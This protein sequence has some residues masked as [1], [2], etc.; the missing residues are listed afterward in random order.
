M[1]TE[2]NLIKLLREK[3]FV[4]NFEIKFI[5]KDKTIKTGLASARII[6][7]DGEEHILSVT[8]DITDWKKAEEKR[9]YLERQVR[10]NQK[11]EAVGNTGRGNCP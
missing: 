8:R 10:Q 5:C 4:H 9:L 6:K 11:M 3:G 1:K 2:K 7:I